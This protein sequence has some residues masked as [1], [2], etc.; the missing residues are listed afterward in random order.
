ME[1]NAQES[2]IKIYKTSDYSIFKKLLQNRDAK[3]EAKIIES[4]Q[5]VGYVPIPLLVNENMELIDGQN[6]LGALKQL[7]LPVYFMK[8]DGIGIEQCRA[9]N[10]GQTNWG[11][12]DYIASFAK[13]GKISYQR[14][15]SLL[16]DYRKP[17]SLQ[18]VYAMAKPTE[19]CDG[20]V[21][22]DGRIKSG[23]FEMTEEEYEIAIKRLASATKLGYVDL[24]KRKKFN[25]RIFW[26]CVSYVYQHSISAEYVIQKLLEYEAVIPPVNTVSEQLKFFDDILNRGARQKNKVYLQADFLKRT[27]LEAEK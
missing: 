9:L 13:E 24:C 5:N 17:F 15:S 3:S 21:R 8:Q 26:S 14:L 19:L 10:I 1:K 2:E 20:G 23:N 7:G 16:N 11:M 27:Y 18:G 22:L 25:A 6:R 12:Y 4:I